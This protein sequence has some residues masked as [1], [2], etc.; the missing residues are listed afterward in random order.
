MKY[1]K[2]WDGTNTNGHRSVFCTSLVQNM[3]LGKIS[4][5]TIKL[6]TI[7]HTTRG[8]N[9]QMPWDNWKVGCTYKSQRSHGVPNRRALS[10]KL[11]KWRTTNWIR[12]TKE[13]HAGGHEGGMGNTYNNPTIFSHLYNKSPFL[14]AWQWI[15]SLQPGSCPV[16]TN[17]DTL[18]QDV[19]RPEEQKIQIEPLKN[20]K[21]ANFNFKTHED[22]IQDM[23]NVH[24]GWDTDQYILAEKRVMLHRND[25]KHI[26]KSLQDI[27]IRN[28]AW[29]TPHPSPLDCWGEDATL[30]LY[31]T[32]KA[33]LRDLT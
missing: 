28:S 23:K 27:S 9:L 32:S 26:I 14:Q 1:T 31:K 30:T 2:T 11:G 13:F 22:L 25:E 5:D 19:V 24:V 29:C 15:S 20:F 4:N 17:S 12:L 21:N 6:W 3:R 16:S 7:F 10:K 18:P 8:L 33:L